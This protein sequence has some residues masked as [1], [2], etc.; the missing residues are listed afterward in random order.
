MK[1][2]LL[3]LMLIGLAFLAQ[4]QQKEKGDF[5]IGIFGG[6]SSPLNKYKNMVD[7]KIGYHGGIFMDKYFS[8]NRWGIGVDARYIYN[9]I[10]PIDSFLFENGFL[11]SNYLNKKRFQDL[12]FTLGPSYKF[13]NNKFQLEAYLR[14]GVMLQSFPEF[15]SSITYADAR[16]TIFTQEIE[17]TVN[18]PSNKANSWVGLGGLRFN[19]MFTPNFGAF[20]HIDYVQSFG[21]EFGG[22]PS[23]FISERLEPLAANAIVATTFVKDYVDHYQ[24]DAKTIEYTVHQT[25]NAGLGIKYV[26]KNTRKPV[27]KPTVVQYSEVPKSVAVEKELQIV[28]KDKQTNIALGGVTVSVMGANFDERSVSDANGQASKIL[29]I[30]PGTYEIT[31]E[32]NGIKTP[33]L[34]LSEADFKGNSKVIFKEIYHDDPRFTLIGETFDCNVERNL[35][36][37]NTVLTNMINKENM[38]QISD[39]EGKFIY[40]LNAQSDFT[41]VANQQGRYSQTEIVSTNGLDRSKTLYVTLKLGVCD[42]QNNAAFVLKNILYDFDKSNI[43]SDAALVLDNV[44]SIMKQNPSLKIE[45]S[46]HTDSRGN[47][48]YNLKL[49]QRRADAAVAYIVSKGISRARLVA[50]GYGESRL[51]NNCGNDVD[52]SEEQH[53]ENRRTEIKVLEYN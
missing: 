30:K 18:D 15:V 24:S 39:A 26:F 51:V 53:Q 4:A 2:L 17:K 33:T 1:K 9:S 5:Q 35:P 14:G 40:Q 47:D 37:I 3:A 28:V 10:A 41:V 48:E 45:L 16:G 43:R 32:K 7:T 8:Q 50:K 42:L 29:S 44:V 6:A 52:C 12:V 34:H 36:N 20:A 31:G 23:R 21:T 27:A 19:Y 46:S 22:K 49:S 13:T 38:S 25:L 11:S